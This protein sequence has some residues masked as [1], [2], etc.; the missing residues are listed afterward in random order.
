MGNPIEM[1]GGDRAKFDPNSDPSAAPAEPAMT[2]DDPA[3]G[4]QP[5][6]NAQ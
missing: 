6:E 3:G 4:V 2:L 5:E 1:P